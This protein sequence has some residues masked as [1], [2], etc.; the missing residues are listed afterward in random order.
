M[1]GTALV[2]EDEHGVRDLV[3][4]YLEREG[5][6]VLATA[7]GA[8]A[9]Q[10][11]ADQPVDVV[12][13][14]LGLPDIDGE[15]VLAVAAD[16]AVPVVVLTARGQV[17]Q[18]IHGLEMGAADYVT[19]PFSPRE[20]V[21]RVQAVLRLSHGDHPHADTA[22]LGNG[23]LVIDQPRHECSLDGQAVD[24][25]PSEWTLLTALTTSPGRVFSRYELANR[26]RGYEFSGYER[27]IDSHV[28]NLRHKL[29]E[30]AGCAAIVQTVPG[31]G[32]KIGLCRDG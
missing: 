9:L 3:R 6:S 24:L 4:R 27:T 2:V 16:A 21:L 28:K 17:A 5:L 7:S 22:S 26:L 31:V 14:D 30:C 23:R 10:A 29:G 12:V 1:I 18:R 8:V 32:Y 25:T 11:L 19:K 15:D 20:L 13:L